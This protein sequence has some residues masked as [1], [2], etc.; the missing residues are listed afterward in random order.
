MNYPF[1]PA[2]ARAVETFVNRQQ[3]FAADLIIAGQAHPGD[4]MEK[5]LPLTLAYFQTMAQQS[6][7]LL[8]FQEDEKVLPGNII[9]FPGGNPAPD[10]K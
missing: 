8:T 10:R 6:V 7:K 1:T 5:A 2:L 9:K 4:A 3:D